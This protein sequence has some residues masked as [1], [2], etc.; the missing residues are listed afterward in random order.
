M[1]IKH[2][3]RRLIGNVFKIQLK[4]IYTSNNLIIFNA[5]GEPN[6]LIF[7]SRAL[8]L[9]RAHKAAQR[10]LVLKVIVS[11]APNEASCW[12]SPTDEFRSPEVL[13]SCSCSEAVVEVGSSKKCYSVAAD[14][15][16]KRQRS[17]RQKQ[18]RV[19]Q[20]FRNSVRKEDVFGLGL[21]GW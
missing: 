18:I 13:S 5:Q 4:N 17:C 2:L 7:L 21:L 20:V 10:I 3:S 1:L 15:Q 14:G 6:E 16:G 11:S 19:K 8:S 9:R 12:V